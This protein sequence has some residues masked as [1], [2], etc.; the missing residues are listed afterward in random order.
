MVAWIPLLFVADLA[1]GLVTGK[2]IIQHVTGFDVYGTAAKAVD[3]VLGTNIAPHVSGDSGGLIE[4]VT[5]N[6]LEFSGGS[7]AAAITG[8]GND[9]G[10]LSAI[11]DLGDSIASAF[12]DLNTYLDDAFSSVFAS[13]NVINDNVLIVMGLCAA[14][15]GVVLVVLLVSASTNRKV[16]RLRK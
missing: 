5:G 1:V 3:N 6:T 11:G 4:A 13:L 15:L 10:I 12:S 16:R 14:I 7:L 2:D 9:E 8:E